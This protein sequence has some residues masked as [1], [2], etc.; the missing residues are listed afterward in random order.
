MY[1]SQYVLRLTAC[2]VDT[3]CHWLGYRVAA[4]CNRG[5]RGPRAGNIHVI[6]RARASVA[7]VAESAA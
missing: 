3:H 7:F 4:A 6:A 1:D 2:P 5:R